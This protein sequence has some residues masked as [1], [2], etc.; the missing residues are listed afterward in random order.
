MLGLAGEDPLYGLTELRDVPAAAVI[1]L[2]NAHEIE[3]S[4]LDPDSY[5]C[6][7]A[8]SSV[9]ICIGTS[10]DAFLIAFDERS[11]HPNENLA[12]FRARHDRF[13]YVDRIIVAEA[14]RGRGLARALYRA[15]LARAILEERRLI[16]CE[17]NLDPPNLASDRLHESIGFAEIG[18]RD[19]AAGKRIRYMALAL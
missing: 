6:L 7:L 14:A 2:N 4:R 16:G 9:A 19:V 15:L 17:I 13:V 3:T 10:P 1:A 18:Q 8:T 12:W 11:D 5:E